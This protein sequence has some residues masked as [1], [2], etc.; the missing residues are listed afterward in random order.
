MASEAGKEVGDVFR[1]QI[2]LGL[3]RHLMEI[4]ER[5]WETGLNQWYFLLLFVFFFFFFF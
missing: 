4:I 1:D 3:V 5:I 2:I